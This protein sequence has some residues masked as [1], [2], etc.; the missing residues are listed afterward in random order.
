MQR[1]P[2]CD[3]VYEEGQRLCDMDGSELVHDPCELPRNPPRKS[4]RTYLL[5]ATT[6]SISYFAVFIPVLYISQVASSN[7]VSPYNNSE[8]QRPAVKTQDL[9]H[10]QSVE[11]GS[12]GSVDGEPAPSTLRS[13]KLK[14]ISSERISSE[15]V[16][17]PHAEMLRPSRSRGK[18]VPRVS[19]R[20]RGTEGAKKEKSKVRSVLRKT[21][22]ILTAPFK[23]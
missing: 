19:E 23:R 6:F 22:R 5:K 15:P 3:F 2:E 10:F 11:F 1:C 14:R 8:V 17:K 4:L 21:A 20:R 7:G 13:T 16:R 18:D 12:A 9:A